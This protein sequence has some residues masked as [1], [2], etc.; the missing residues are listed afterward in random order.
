MF[1]SVNFRAILD[2]LP[3]CFH[4]FRKPQHVPANAGPFEYKFPP[5]STLV[6][7]LSKEWRKELDDF[8]NLKK[9]QKFTTQTVQVWTKTDSLTAR[10]ERARQLITQTNNT[11]LMALLTDIDIMTLLSERKS[12][13]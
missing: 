6:T 8:E 9:I 1:S 12:L 11:E 4:A 10:S 3:G 2:P 7:D 5:N 13:L